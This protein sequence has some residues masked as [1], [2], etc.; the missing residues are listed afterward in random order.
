MENQAGSGERALMVLS[1]LARVLHHEKPAER[2]EAVPVCK[3]LSLIF[4]LAFGPLPAD[5]MEGK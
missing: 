3:P 5:K 2:R 1:E 4:F